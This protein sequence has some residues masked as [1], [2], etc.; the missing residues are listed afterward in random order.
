[1]GAENSLQNRRSHW[2]P[3]EGDGSLT[4]LE[5]E[6]AVKVARNFAVPSVLVRKP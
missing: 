5:L 3:K 4:S 6:D 2:Q 1:M